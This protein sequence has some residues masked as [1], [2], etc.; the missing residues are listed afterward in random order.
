[1][2]AHPGFQY[3]HL[4]AQR[5]GVNPCAP[6]EVDTGAFYDWTP[7]TKGKFIAPREGALDASGHFNLVLH[8]HGDDPVRRELVNSGQKLV[9]HTITLNPNQ[10][11][12]TLFTGTGLFESIVQQVEQS[13]AKKYGRDTHVGHIAL[14]AWSAG[15]TGISAILAQSGASGVDAVVLIDGLNA[16]RQADILARQLQPFVEFAGRAAMN[17]RFMLVT[18]SSIDPPDFASTTETAHFL[19]SAL[20]GHPQAVRRND[21]L[22]LELVEFFTR[23]S[24]HVRGYAGNGKADHCAQLALL[25]DAF[26][27]LGNRWRH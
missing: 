17:E 1:V 26:E 21:S 14:S 11:Y 12:A 8:F 22:G 19:I 16:P 9:L 25:R 3:S 27:A 10:N 7:L 4:S 15:F 18:H 23:G 20:G 24:F 5:G 13:L 6:Q 2:T